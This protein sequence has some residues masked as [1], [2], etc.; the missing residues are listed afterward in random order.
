[1][2][3]G[4]GE[5]K[6]AVEEGAGGGCKVIKYGQSS[7]LIYISRVRYLEMVLASRWPG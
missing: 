6:G 7:E 5:A 2:T 4:E 1:M 3:G